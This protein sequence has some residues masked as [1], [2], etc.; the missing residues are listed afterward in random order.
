MGVV[1]QPAVGPYPNFPGVVGPQAAG[2]VDVAPLRLAGAV[3]LRQEGAVVEQALAGDVQVETVVGVMA[4]LGGGIF[5]AAAGQGTQVADVDPGLDLALVEAYLPQVDDTADVVKM[6]AGVDKAVV[7]DPGGTLRVPLA[8]LYIAPLD[9]PPVDQLGAADTPGGPLAQGNS[10]PLGDQDGTGL[11]EAVPDLQGD[12]AVDDHRSAV[13]IQRG[14]KLL[15]GAYMDGPGEGLLLGQDQA[16][17]AVH[18]LAAVEQDGPALLHGEVSLL[19]RPQQV[20]P[21]QRPLGGHR[22]GPAALGLQQAVNI[23]LTL[24][25]EGASRSHGDILD[26]IQPGAGLHPEGLAELQ[27]LGHDDIA[28]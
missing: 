15:S 20:D 27:R 16:V 4:A 19:L 23:R 7:D 5:D 17:I 24:H 2:Q 25:P 14:H 10:D 21:V 13:L 9:G 11:G 18:G 6:P 22:D 8:L 28:A 3:P 26:R 12:I 1:V